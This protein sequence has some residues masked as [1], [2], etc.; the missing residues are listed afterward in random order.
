MITHLACIMD[1]NRRWAI[2]K[3]W[4]PWHG[5]R[6]GIEAA[7]RVIDFC[8]EKGITYLSV[9]TFSI[10]NFKRSFEE[11]N[12]LF[13][14]LVNQASQ[15]IEEL[16]QK[17]VR[18][19]FIGDR[20]LFPESIKKI[21]EKAEQETAHFNALHLNLLFCYGAQQEI[22]DAV[23]RVVHEVRSGDFTLDDLSSETFKR[24]LWTQDTP[25]PDLI[26]RTGGRHRLSNFLLYQAAYS[27]LYFLDCLWP[28]M[29]K[30][31]LEK[32]INHF[33]QCRR[34]FGT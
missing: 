1:G 7:K 6:E 3:G 8:I 32:A 2:K 23:K 5:H 26:I 15:I 28:D 31:H 13:E 17:K 22:V 11:K 14:V 12:Y 21:C 9:Y 33:N 20:S 24:F 10:E 34:N 25:D 19:R 30:S 4:I 18:I 16:K 29:T 27:E